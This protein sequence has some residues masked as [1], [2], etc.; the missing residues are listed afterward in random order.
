MSKIIS[1]TEGHLESNDT[2]FEHLRYTHE[3]RKVDKTHILL[4]WPSRKSVRLW[5][6]R[7]ALIL[8]RVKLMT[9]K[10]LFL[11]SLLDAHH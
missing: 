10:L 5:S 9:A 1:F 6:C 4:Q 3:P 11:V 8:S 7:S 2:D